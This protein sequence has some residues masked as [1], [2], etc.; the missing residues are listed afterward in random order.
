MKVIIYFYGNILG[1]TTLTAEQ[2]TEI[3]KDDGVTVELITE[4][5]SA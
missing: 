4:T 2:I 1:V 5:Q 3:Q